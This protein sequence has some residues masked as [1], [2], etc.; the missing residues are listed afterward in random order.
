MFVSLAAMLSQ[1]VFTCNIGKWAGSEEWEEVE[2]L[3]VGR[4]KQ[5]VLS[6]FYFH[7]LIHSILD[8]S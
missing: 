6:D 1:V 2:T 3:P 4:N 8:T 7:T 5:T